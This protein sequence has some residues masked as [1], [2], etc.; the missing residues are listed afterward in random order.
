MWA[1]AARSSRVLKVHWDTGHFHSRPDFCGKYMVPCDGA[2][3]EHVKGQHRRSDVYRTSR[4][5]TGICP[6]PVLLVIR[7]GRLDTRAVR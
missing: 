6:E 1:S 5:R 7:I 2:E 3:R 4:T